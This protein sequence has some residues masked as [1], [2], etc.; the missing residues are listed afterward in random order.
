MDFSYTRAYTG[1][2]RLAIFDWAGTIIDYG[3][4]APAY[5]F[6]EGFKKQ[7][8]SITMPQAREPMGMEKR[9]HIKAVTEMEEIAREWQ[10]AHGRP[11]AEEDI[12]RMFE[13]FVPVLLNVL[14]DHSS[15]IPGVVDTINQLRGHGLKIAGTTGYFKEAADIGARCAASEGYIPDFTISASEVPAGRPFPWM[16]YRVMEA[17]ETCP[18]EAVV[19]V[20]DTVVDVEAGINAG[21]WTVGIA[22]TGN[23]TGLSLSAMAIADP[24]EVEARVSAARKKLQQTGAHYVIDSVA[25]MPQVVKEIN[26]RLANGE[27]P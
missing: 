26:R 2:L 14:A 4:C 18:P 25:D 8:V 7:G 24:T 21:V 23:E 6:I 19:N 12:D 5:A 3:C 27:K 13:E 15:V 9:A 1:P 22:R 17:L 16:I 11:V 10:R 20:G